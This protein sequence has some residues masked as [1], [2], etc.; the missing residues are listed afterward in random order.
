MK[1]LF[2][3][4]YS[5]PE[6]LSRIGDMSQLAGV[7]PVELMNGNE[8]GVRALEFTTG[9]GLSFTVLTDRGFDIYDARFNG[10]SLCWHS[11]SGPAAPAFYDPYNTGWLW[12]FPG[13]LLTTCGL[14]NVGDPQDKME[15]AWG[16]H[17]RI[18]NTPAKNVSFGA[19]WENDDY[20]LGASGEMREARL[21]GPNLL[22]RRNIYARLGE[23][24]IWIKDEIE[25]QGH[26]ETPL[27]ILYHCNIGYP[28]LDKDT[29]FIAVIED[30]EPRDKT[31]EAEI[32]N[33]DSFTEPVPGFKE[34][35]FY[36]DHDVDQNGLVNSAIINRHYNGNQG[37]GIYMMYLKDELPYFT[38][39]KMTGQ[40][41]YIVA[42]EPGNCY[43][44]GQLNAQKRNA[45]TM[46]PPGGKATFNLEIGVLESNNEIRTFE[47]RLRELDYE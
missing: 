41:A 11:P 15:E 31:A 37:I 30:M 9:S 35:Y 43:P 5:K 23:S 7:K 10:A 18:S 8:R 2:G 22:L 40:G 25:N 6:L 12:S 38:Q 20:I 28:L 24:K 42:L 14:S 45:L 17:G 19:E 39:W 21:F 27:M 1:P 36:I 16:L 34:Q 32:D 13:G 3:K 4:S 44:E 47:A 29:E 33:F 26:Q 46:L